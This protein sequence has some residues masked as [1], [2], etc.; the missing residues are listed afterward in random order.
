MAQPDVTGP[1][2][3]APIHHALWSHSLTRNFEEARPTSPRHCIR[4]WQ[5]F[6]FMIF[7]AVSENKWWRNLI[8]KWVLLV[9]NASLMEASTVGLNEALSLVIS[10]QGF[11]RLKNNLTQW[12]GPLSLVGDTYWCLLKLRPCMWLSQEC[13]R[14][15]V[16]ELATQAGGPELDPQHPVRI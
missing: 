16:K 7:W 11:W 2:V 5:R 6:S 3:P 10:F 4:C 12:L 1:F 14:S 13:S 8:L 9:P 15:P